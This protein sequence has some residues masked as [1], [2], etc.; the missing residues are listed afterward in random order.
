MLLVGGNT[1]VAANAVERFASSRPCSII[2]LGL[3]FASAGWVPH[4]L[5]ERPSSH[6]TSHHLQHGQ[7]TGLNPTCVVIALSQVQVRH[8]RR[9]PPLR[10]RQR[11]WSPGVSVPSQTWST[12]RTR[13]SRQSSLE[14]GRLVSL[15]RR[16]TFE[17]PCIKNVDDCVMCHFCKTSMMGSPFAAKRPSRT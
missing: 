1:L 6:Q 16:P 10:D 9:H 5:K 4:E 14:S 12:S 3:A 7:P 2:V 15:H 8:P 17:M 13:Q 11:G